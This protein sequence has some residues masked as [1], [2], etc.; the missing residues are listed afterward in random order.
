MD[1]KL[2]GD[3]EN[4]GIFA[5]SG[6]HCSRCAFWA[7]DL[8]TEVDGEPHTVLGVM[9][10][11]FY[12]YGNTELAWKPLQMQTQD[13]AEASR[14]VHSIFALILIIAIRQG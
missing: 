1:V 12:V 3:K 4:G 14:T 13:V 8:A 9:P 10:P 5:V 6:N 2:Y 11:G 7:E